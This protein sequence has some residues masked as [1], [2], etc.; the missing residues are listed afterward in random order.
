MSQTLT[1]SDTL[2]AKLETTVDRLG[3][4]SIEHLLEIWQQNED[5]RFRRQSAVRHIDLLRENLFTRY[6]QMPDSVDLI[7]EDRGR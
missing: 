5:E 4:S 6:G 7:R 1:I 2:Y 3:L